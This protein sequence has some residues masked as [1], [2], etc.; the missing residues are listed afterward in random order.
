LTERLARTLA[1][2]ARTKYWRWLKL[3]TRPSALR[4]WHCRRALASAHTDV[5][6]LW[7]RSAKVGYVVDA[8]GA[9]RCIHWEHGA[10]WDPGHERDRSRYFSRVRRAIANSHAAARVLQLVWGYS[11]DVRVCRNALRPSLLPTTAR[12]KM[13][14]TARVTL[15][16][17][18]RLYPVKGVALVLH[19]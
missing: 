11:G 15:G 14:P 4:A 2:R 5:L 9:E 8:A 16:V 1:S 19:A 3:P 12:T 6:L 10:A 13:R 18:A 17:A 7:N